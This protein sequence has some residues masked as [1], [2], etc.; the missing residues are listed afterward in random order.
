MSRC[1]QPPCP[2][3][4]A[5]GRDG[6]T[7]LIHVGVL[8]SRVR[9]SWQLVG[10]KTMRSTVMQRTSR[11]LVLTLALAALTVQ[12]AAQE[13]ERSDTPD[14]YKW[15]LADVYPS[16][17]AWRAA[18]ERIQGELPGLREFEG[19]LASASA[20]ADALDMRFGLGKELSRVYVYASMLADQDTRDAT[21]QGMRQ[22]MVQIAAE[23]RAQASY[24]E[25]E[26]LRLDGGAVE[27][28]LAEEPRLGI[29]RVY[30]E[31]I[32]R[33]APHT[34]SPSEEKILADAGPL[35][36]SPSA[37]YNILANAEFPYPTVRLSDGNEVRINQANFGAYRLSANRQDR[38]TV[39][40]AF[41]EGLGSFSRTFG[42][43]MNGRVQKLLFLAKS[44]RYPTS[45]ESSLNDAN[46]PVSVYTRLIEG[47]N[48]NLP[49]FHRY[50]RLRKRMMG[51]EDL[52]YYDLYAPL[53]DS[54]NLNYSPE[55]AQEHVLAAMAPLGDDY[56]S[57]LKRAFEERWIDL[58]PSPGKRS[59]A[60]SNGGAYDVHP[61]MLINY[62]GKYDDVSTL[63]HELGHTMQSYYSNQTQPYPTADYPIFVAEVAS[64]FNESLLIDH[65]LGTITDDDVRLSL[66]GNY[67]E[68]IKGTVFRQT[69]F[70][71]FELRMHEMAQAGHAITGEALAKLYLDITRKYYGHDEGVCIVDDYIAHE[72]SY[73]PHFY[74]DF[75]VFQYATSFTASEALAQ[76]VKNRDP[77][78][79]KRYLT[80]LSAGGSKYPIDLLKD[81]GVDMATNEPLDLTMKEMN[82][83]MD[84]M[85]KL[86]ATRPATAQP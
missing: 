44:R 6:T 59:G 43:T 27:R 18:K 48:E 14:R 75:Y 79:I 2:A 19:K 23:F 78:A 58:Y 28:F 55:E 85:E 46:I 36:G 16:V 62:N 77:E 72:W 13:R 4:E 67:L 33:R 49:A 76:K 10:M 65:M 51:V 60:Y 25:P 45:L 3:I 42:A 22:E 61:Y 7:R 68:G 80:F 30:L 66:L 26:I 71:E 50:L 35:A 56:V 29:Y 34:L 84:E 5:F 24:I 63:A 64:T 40:S 54:V 39:M 41:F 8:Q 81:A 37:I 70:A 15:N 83:V 86:L 52:H 32:A 74:R 69:Q 20:L 1:H 31:D 12:V 38:Q 82:R 17:E 47:V 9:Q 11:L 57:V 53:V 21:P 73:I